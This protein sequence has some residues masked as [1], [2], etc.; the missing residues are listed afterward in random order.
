[1]YH[2]KIDNEGLTVTNGG[3]DSSGR[4][5]KKKRGRGVKVKER[6]ESCLPKIEEL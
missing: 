3:D 1:M 6:G 2:L 4:Y 5:E